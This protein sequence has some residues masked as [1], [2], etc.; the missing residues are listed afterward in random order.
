MYF[1]LSDK[2]SYKA[3]LRKAIYTL[4]RNLNFIMKVMWET[5]MIFGQI[6]IMIR[7]DFKEH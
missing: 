3:Q 4:I 6:N 1:V 5:L 2:I 7:A